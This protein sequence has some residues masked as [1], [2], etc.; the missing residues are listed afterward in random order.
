MKS[1]NAVYGDVYL[2]AD[3]FLILQG[4]CFCDVFCCF[5]NDLGV[6]NRSLFN[7]YKKKITGQF[8]L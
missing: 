5:L 6:K 1:K 3:V 2:T 8:E 7:F 4:S